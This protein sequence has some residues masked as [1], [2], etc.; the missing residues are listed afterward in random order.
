MT[1]IKI[2]VWWDNQDHANEGWAYRV[3]GGDDDRDEGPL[4]SL[5]DNA[6]GT[7]LQ[8]AVVSIAHQHGVTIT[9]DDVV[10][11]PNIDGGFAEW[12]A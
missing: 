9:S 1:P 2:T 7:A 12:T 5:P 4:D 3:L 10:V 11:E 6:D 8:D